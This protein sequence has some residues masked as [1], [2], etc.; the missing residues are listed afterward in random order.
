M[1][2]GLIRARAASISF[3]RLVRS[4]TADGYTVVRSPS[5]QVWFTTR[6]LDSD[7]AAAEAMLRQHK[8]Y[9]WD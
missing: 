2:I 6:G 9:A 8:L 1:I 7:P 3:S 4:M 5:N